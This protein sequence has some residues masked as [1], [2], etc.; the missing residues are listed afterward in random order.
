MHLIRSLPEWPAVPIRDLCSKVTSGGTPSRKEPFFYS[1]SGV[2]WLKT[3][4]IRDEII[5]DAEEHITEAGLARSSA[6]LLPANTVLVAMYGATAGKLAILG[7]PMACNQACCALIV[8]PS[9]ADY[10]FLYY[11][12][13]AGRDALISLANGAAQQNLSVGV[14]A[15]ASI[16][17]PSLVEQKAITALLG[18]LDDK[19]AVN[20]RVARTAEQILRMNFAA[21]SSAAPDTIR[22]DELGVQ[23]RDGVNPSAINGTEPYVGLEHVPRKSIWLDSW[24]NASEVSSVKT[25]FRAGDFL[26]GKLR[27]YFHKVVLA[28]VDG[29]CSTDIIVVRAVKE[30]VGTWVLMSLSSDE[31]VAHATARSDGTRMPRTKWADLA[32]YEISWP[33]EK[34]AEEF[35]GVAQPLV[36]R[37]QAASSESRRLAEL[38]DMLLPKLISGELRIKDA[39]QL[40]SDAV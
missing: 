7:S 39:E 3:Q 9:R 14:I 23:V 27:P 38:R 26:F 25:S 36:N 33:G 15:N 11:S 22:I 19:I 32:E 4:E 29:V 30:T 18:G 37:V 34:A 16:P 21:V 10:R 20:G 31:V 28:P 2:P 1:T 35:H 17:V 12:L 40:V 5:W 8:D 24:G 6:K 13:L